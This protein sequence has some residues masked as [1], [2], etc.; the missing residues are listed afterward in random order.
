M[1]FPATQLVMWIVPTA[2]CQHDTWYARVSTQPWSFVI[3]AS[4]SLFQLV[5]CDNVQRDL[6]LLWYRLGI[7]IHYQYNIVGGTE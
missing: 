5:T 3:D 6:P 2:Q 4:P 7:S 1:F